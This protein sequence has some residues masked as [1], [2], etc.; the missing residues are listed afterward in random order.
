MV[1]PQYPIS[2]NRDRS[3]PPDSKDAASNKSQ[4]GAA[5]S[6]AAAPLRDD[7]YAATGIGRNVRNDVYFVD[8]DLDS[9]AAGEVTIRYEYY[10]ALLRLGVVPREQS[11]EPLR[12]RE[13][14]RGFSPEP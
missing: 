3:E 14:S 1:T 10:S 5:E 7:D 12:R 9:R 8:M 6:R 2:K 13:D 4:A 11:R